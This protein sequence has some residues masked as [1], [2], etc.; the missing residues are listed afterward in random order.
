M[1]YLIYAFYDRDGCIDFHV[2][3]SL[4]KYSKYFFDG[5]MIPW[6]D[7]FDS[8]MLIFNREHKDFFQKIIEF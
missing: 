2:L 3:N 1:N 8:G 7:Y 4:H 5:Y 6:T